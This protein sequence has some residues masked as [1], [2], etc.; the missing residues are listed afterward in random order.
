MPSSRRQPRPPRP[1]I[2]VEHS[3]YLHVNKGDVAMLDVTV[4]RIREQ[5]PDARVGVLTEAAA[6][7]RIYV[8]DAEPVHP[9]GRT[10]WRAPARWRSW[11]PHSRAVAGALVNLDLAY[12]RVRSSLGRRA[13][14]VLGATRSDSTEDRSV[15]RNTRSALPSASLVL[16]L[17]GGYLTDV[18]PEQAGRLLSL[19][20]LAR[21]E[22]IPAALF[23]QG[24]GPLEDPQLVGRAAEVLPHIAFIGL[25]EGIYGPDALLRI[26]VPADRFTVT[27]DDAIELAHD[28]RSSEVGEGLG[29]CLRIADYSPV[30][31]EVQ[32][33]LATALQGVAAGMDAWLVPVQISEYH[34]EDRRATAPLVEGYSRVRRPLGRHSHPRDIASRISSCRV[35][36]T[37][38]Y[39]AAVFALSQGIPVVG[40]SSSPYYDV[41]FQ[42][43]SAMFDG[44]L[45]LVSLDPDGLDQRLRAAIATAWGRAPNVRESLLR[46]AREQIEE[47]RSAY[48]R[49]L[50]GVR[51]HVDSP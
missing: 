31:T 10:G 46:Q 22:D 34:D 26:G 38:A 15:P 29:I 8:P 51:A 25:R 12:R 41:K 35:L 13:L 48:A 24:I 6:L 17:G 39:H 42:G 19:A 11:A 9:W 14:G 43:L 4:R 47:S 2:L 44:G 32:R 33:L 1:M 45:E 16:G 37:G 5:L 7:L 40:L 36:V 28:V 49:V 23:G 20:E 3:D 50:S 30:T 21:A 18:D 27:G